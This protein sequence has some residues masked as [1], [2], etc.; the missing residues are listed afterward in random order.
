[1]WWD[2]LLPLYLSR[3]IFGQRARAIM[4]DTQM[5]KHRFFSKIGAFS[6]D[7]SDHRSTITSL[8]YAVESTNRP[9]SGLYI[10]PEGELTPVSNSRPDFKQGLAWI[11]QNIEAGVDLVPIAFDSN[12]FRHSKPELYINIGRPI[13]IDKR[14]NKSE[15]TSV[16]E[17]EIQMLLNETRSV[18][19]LTDHGF[20]KQ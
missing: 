10:Y 13:T 19:G 2:G 11:Y 7:L 8:R 9:N 6:I 4:E 16:F 1:M 15:L 12:N 17:K 14:S 20:V 3:N 5:I 18:A